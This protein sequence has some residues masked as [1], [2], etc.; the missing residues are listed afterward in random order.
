M[1][2]IF[3]RITDDF[4]DQASF[5]CNTNYTALSESC[6]PGIVLTPENFMDEYMYVH[7]EFD[8]FVQKDDQTMRY[9]LGN[10][11]YLSHPWWICYQTLGDNLFG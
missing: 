4:I 8:Q 10:A 2:L 5:G 7:E 3:G 11:I 1:L 9:F 6:P